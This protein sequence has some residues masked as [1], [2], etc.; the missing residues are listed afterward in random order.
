MVGIKPN[1]RVVLLSRNAERLEMNIPNAHTLGMLY[2]T[3]RFG[4]V[5]RVFRYGGSGG[6]GPIFVEVD[7][8]EIRDVIFPGEETTIEVS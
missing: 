8:H 4:K 6:T 1:T 5:S 7:A 3:D 2:T